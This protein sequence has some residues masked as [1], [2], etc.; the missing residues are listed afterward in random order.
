MHVVWCRVDARR[1]VAISDSW[2]Y[3]IHEE[4]ARH[5]ERIF[6][7]QRTQ[8]AFAERDAVARP[9]RTPST[10]EMQQAARLRIDLAALTKEV[11]QIW[12]QTNGAAAFQAALVEHGYVLARGDRRQYVLVDRAGG[13]HSLARRIEGARVAAIRERLSTLDLASLPSID[14][15]REKQREV[16]HAARL[17]S[18]AK[19]GRVPD[20]V[21]PRDSI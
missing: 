18:A 9:E 21:K 20:E 17:E 19:A 7:H 3:A 5:L 13:V 14:E 1:K 10:A 15:A 11:T 6:G 4:A 8:G 12:R 16:G 2:N